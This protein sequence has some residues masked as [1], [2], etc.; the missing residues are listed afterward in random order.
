MLQTSINLMLAHAEKYSVLPTVEQIYAETGIK[1]EKLSEFNSGH[2]V[3]ALD[4]IESFCRHK[5]CTSAVLE[6]AKRINNN[7]TDGIEKLIKEAVLTSLQ[8]DLGLNYFEDPLT[9]LERTNNSLA[10]LP[11]GWKTLD[12]IL[13]GGFMWGEL[14]YFVAPTGGGKSVGLQNLAVNWAN[15]GLD[16]LY[17][18]HE[19]S[20]DLVAKRFDALW[21]DVT[22]ADHKKSMEQI[23]TKLAMISKTGKS[24]HIQIKYLPGQTTSN[25]IESY[26]QEYEIQF[27]THPEIIIVDYADLMRPNDKNISLENVSIRDK[28]VAEE[29]RSIA[30]TRTESGKRTSIF[31]ASQ[32]TKDGVD[33]SSFS[34]S[35]VAGGATKTHTCDNLISLYHSLSMDDRNELE[36]TILKTRNSGSRNV[37]ITMNYN[38]QTLRITDLVDWEDRLKNKRTTQAK[39]KNIIETPTMSNVEIDDETKERNETLS[40]ILNKMKK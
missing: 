26:L 1:I 27:N 36:L 23:A 3:A 14:N 18:T 8:R 39:P 4:Y 21:T 22:L 6:C 15:E 17:I 9:R 2:R 5:A 40:N 20:Q 32:I 16:V 7:Q 24:K 25:T 13:G 38:P 35:K 37:K 10:S 11:S 29:L 28:L 34:L 12:K 30:A 31:T 33:E 19:L